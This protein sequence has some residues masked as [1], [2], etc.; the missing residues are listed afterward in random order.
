MSKKKETT[1]FQTYRRTV[2]TIIVLVIVH[3]T[4]LCW[5]D[6][7]NAF[8][9]L[10]ASGKDTPALTTLAAMTFVGLRMYL[11]LVV[12]GMAMARIGSAT[13]RWYGEK[14][15]DPQLAPAE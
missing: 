5:L 9:I 6:G 8:A 1:L 2:L 13:L 11:Y 12:P 4:L 7:S 14:P 10:T 15:S 3:Y